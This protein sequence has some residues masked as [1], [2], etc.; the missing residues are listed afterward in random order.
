MEW[1]LHSPSDYLSDLIRELSPPG[2]LD[3]DMITGVCVIDHLK[4][5]QR[6]NMVTKQRL[7]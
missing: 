5:S 7:C 1:W 6:E 2:M 3:T 4:T